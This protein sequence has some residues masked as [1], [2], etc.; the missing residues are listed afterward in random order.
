M[1]KKLENSK[2]PGYDIRVVTNKTLK[3]LS[4]KTILLITLIFNSMI[5]IKYYALI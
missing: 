1:I 5:K 2:S 4:N 3:H